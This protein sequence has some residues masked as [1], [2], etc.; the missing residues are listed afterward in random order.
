MRTILIVLSTSRYSE[1]MVD[2]AMTEAERRR[3][4]GEPVSIEV[5]YVIETGELNEIYRSVGEVGFLGT[6]AQKEVIDTLAAEY[7]RTARERMGIIADRAREGGFET[8]TTE[9][10]G[11]FVQ[12]IHEL[13]ETERFDVI[14]LTRAERPFI[15]R[16]LFGSKCETV[17]RLVREEGLS[18]VVIGD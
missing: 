8:K 17:A 14:Y 7:H 6:R 16:F 11:A 5:V 1:E 13:A 2:R 12:V 9:R 15:S 3:S 18:E 10:E 4:A